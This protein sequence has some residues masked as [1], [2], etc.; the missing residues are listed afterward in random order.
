[1]CLNQV[2]FDDRLSHYIDHNK[3][4]QMNRAVSCMRPKC[5]WSSMQKP[6]I[7]SNNW[8]MLFRI[9]VYCTVRESEYWYSHKLC[10]YRDSYL[11]IMWRWSIISSLATNKWRN[12][13]NNEHPKAWNCKV[14]TFERIKSYFFEMYHMFGWIS[15]GR[16]YFGISVEVP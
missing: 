9:W 4:F 15:D 10:F 6:P 5:L 8:K 12:R 7:D 13:E 1:M 3:L 14:L 16:K 11:W 2:S